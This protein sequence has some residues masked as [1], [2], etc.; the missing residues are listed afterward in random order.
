MC[1]LVSLC[2]EQSSGHSFLSTLPTIPAEITRFPCAFTVESGNPREQLSLTHHCPVSQ[3]SLCAEQTG[4]AAGMWEG[5]A[6]AQGAQNGLRVY[7]S[8]PGEVNN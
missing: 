4:G 5:A 7:R 2:I 6:K 8:H 1:L 3:D